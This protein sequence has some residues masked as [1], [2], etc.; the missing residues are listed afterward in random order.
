MA[1]RELEPWGG[2]VKMPRWL[3]RLLR[4]P[5][6]EESTWEARHEA[7]KRQ[8]TG[9]VAENANRASAGPLVDLYREDKGGRR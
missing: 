8:S 7:R 9:S 2:E 5:D 6:P 3:R 4:R 1:H